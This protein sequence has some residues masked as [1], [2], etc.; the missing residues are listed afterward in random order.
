MFCTRTAFG[1]LIPV[2]AKIFACAIPV[3]LM[4]SRVAIPGGRKISWQGKCRFVLIWLLTLVCAVPQVTGTQAKREPTE[5]WVQENYE[6]IVDLI[7]QDKGCAALKS[8]KL[9]RWRVCVRVIPG[10]QTE[11]EY[12]LSL[13]KRYDGTAHVQITRP[14]GASIFTQLVKLKKEHG[15]P[16]QAELTRRARAIRNP[17]LHC[18]VSPISLRRSDF[19]LLR[20]MS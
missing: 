3:G 9:A 8:P 12:L 15:N 7:S 10:H 19:R 17:F 16:L 13:D 2:A 1:K 20:P 14:Q 6:A 11:L 18:R 5:V 4:S